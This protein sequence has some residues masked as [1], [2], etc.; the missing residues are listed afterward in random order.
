MKLLITFGDSWTYGVGVNYQTGMSADEFY[1]DAWNT[2]ILNQLSFRNLLCQRFNMDHVNF[3]H[4]GASNQGQFRIAEDYFASNDFREHRSKYDNITVLWGITSVFRTEVYFPDLK[5]RK[6]VF[7]SDGSD[8]AKAIMLNHF[9]QFHEVNLLLK[10]MHYWNRIFDLLGIRNIWFDTF[11]HHDYAATIPPGQEDAYSTMQRMFG[12]DL[13]PRD[14]L[15]LLALRNG[16]MPDSKSYHLSDWSV[17]DR[18]NKHL[19]QNLKELIQLEVLN[20][21]SNHPTELGHQQIADILA[22]CFS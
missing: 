20:P 1:A 8:L 11:N 2:E 3:A 13:Q 9:D 15:S 5:I 12:Q 16:I 10:K 17:K 14:L 22:P 21:Y 7:Y 18:Q 6:S 4:G 19:T